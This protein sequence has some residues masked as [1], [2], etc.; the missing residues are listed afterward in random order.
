[1][2]ARRARRALLTL[3][4]LAALVPALAPGNAVAH[5]V[6][7]GTDPP[8]GTVLKTQPEQ[9][10]FQ[11]TEPVEGAFGAIRVFD[12]KAARAEQG[13]AFHPDDAGSRLAARLRPDLAQGTYTATYRVI[14][15]DG[16]PVSG[17]LLF[18]VGKATAA[19][20]VSELLGDTGTGG[21]TT[22]IGFGASRAIQYGATALAIGAM[23]FLLVV[24]IPGL[25][26]VAGGEARWR[27]ASE[28]F[29]SRLR[30]LVIGA[31]AAG[32]VSGAL[33]IVFQGATAA[34]V[35]FWDALDPNVVGDVLDTRFGTVWGLRLV[36]WLVLAVG[37]AFVLS[38]SRRPVL[39]S[40]SVGATGSALPANSPGWP[41]IAAIGVPLG[42]L[43]IAPALAGHANLQSPSGVTFSANVV[44]V[45]A[46]S[47][48]TGG[49]TALLFA[50]PVATRK[51]EPPDRPRLLASTVARF[52]TMAGAAVALI[53]LT[54]I[55]QSLVEVRNLDNLTGT[56][57]GRSALIKF[58]LL[59]GPLVA[60]GAYNRQRML[61][62]LRAIAAGGKSLGTTGLTFRRALRGEIA[63]VV[64]VLGVTAALAS[65]PPATSG[66]KGPVSV[67]ERLGPAEATLTVDPARIGPNVMHVYINDA[68]TGQ[69]FD[70][71]KEFAVR[72]ALPDKDIGPLAQSARRA[73]PGHYV[74]DGASFGVSG[75]WRVRLTAR[76]S[77]FDQYSATM[78][79]PIR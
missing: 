75:D 72:L 35:S 74:M 40:A 60:L 3:A 63:L 2:T 51:L 1:V 47:T 24:W 8:S 78:E 67:T 53:L 66:S 15:A 25:L 73:G 28:A 9:V 57:F 36:V 11:F 32:V 52:S 12:R 77:E 4:A 61:P 71:T 17:G 37:F 18:S 34:G 21:P 5:A 64:V 45:L 43:A 46:V 65:Y 19:A 23:I 56:A 26:A 48:W 68:R 39:R 42:L 6:L 70:R 27:A 13:D 50:L 33:G 49:L 44:H 55:A 30:V 79:V 16:H 22:Q 7:T 58:C 38:G 29:A 20:S 10:E 54:G 59:V 62:R 31:V 41:A 76:V 69:P 14:S